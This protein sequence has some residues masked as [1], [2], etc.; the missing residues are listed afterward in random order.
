MAALLATDA[1]RPRGERPTSR[2]ARAVGHVAATLGLAAVFVASTVGGA[3]LHLDLGPAR[4]LVAGVV[5]ATVFSTAFTGRL[6][7]GAID[8]LGL[9]GVRIRSFD[10]FDPDGHRVVHADGIEA[11]FDALSNVRRIASGDLDIV[12]A[13]AHIVD[14]DA[15]ISSRDGVFGIAETFTP[16]PLPVPPPPP[17]PPTVPPAPLRFTIES[18]V[19]DHAAGHGEL[20]PGVHLDGDVRKVDASLHVLPDTVM[21]DVDTVEVEERAITPF[22]VSGVANYHLRV[23]SKERPDSL[24]MWTG[25]GGKIGEAALTATATI[26]DDVLKAHVDV[27]RATPA[28]LAGFAPGLELRDAVT[29]SGDLDGTIPTFSISA[30][31]GLLGA[32]GSTGKIDVDG[33]LDAVDGARV[34]ADVHAVDV[35]LG[36]VAPVTA[37]P[38][39]ADVRVRVDLTTMRVTA[40][41]TTQ[42]F[43]IEGQ[44]VPAVQAFAI[45][46]DGEV[47]GSATIDEDGAPTTAA[48]HVRPSGDVRFAATADVPSLQAFPRIPGAPVSGSAHVKV[49]GSLAGGALDARVSGTASGLGVGNDVRVSRAVI[50]GR[51]HG[52]LAA[53]VLDAG[54][55]GGGLQAGTYDFDTY[56][57]RATGPLLA[58][59][60]S[61][62]LDGKANGQVTARAEVDA[63]TASAHAITLS[64]KK[65]DDE[66]E[67]KVTRVGVVRGGVAIEGVS[68]EGEKVG[69]VAANLRIDRGELVGRV[70]GDEVDVQ[71]LARLLSLPISAKGI[72]NVDVDLALTPRG[73]KGH[74]SI[75]I[76][77]G[78]FAGI[79]GVST[80]F[81][82][83]FDDRKVEA[84]ALV[85]LVSRARPEDK[86]HSCDGAIARVRIEQGEGELDGPLL[87]PRT[88]AH[89][90]GSARISAEQWDLRCLAKLGPTALVLSDVKGRLGVRFTVA[91]GKGDR[92]PSVKDLLAR[93]TEL[94]LA[95]PIPSGSDSPSWESRH[96]DVQLNGDFDGRTG[97]TTARA[98]VLDEKV[99]A[100]VDVRASPDVARLIDDPAGRFAS[101]RKMPL[102]V[103][104]RMPRRPMSS[105]TS[106]PSFVVAALPAAVGDLSA[107][108]R[109]DGTLEKPY[110]A[111][112]AHARGL[113]AA[114]NGVADA[115]PWS[116]PIEAELSGSYDGD[117]ATL[118]VRT[119]HGDKTLLKAEARVEDLPMAALL[120]GSIPNWKGSVHAQ[121]KEAPVGDIPFFVD[122]E[123]SGTL[124]GAL[125]VEGLHQK[126]T[127]HAELD[128]PGLR[129]GED[130][131]FT[132][133]K[134]VLDVTREGAASVEPGGVD[135]A[136]ARASVDLAG[137]G[138]GE[139][140]VT[141]NAGVIWEGGVVPL[142]DPDAPGGVEVDASRFRLLALQPAV[143]GVLSK[144]DGLLDGKV[145]L[146]WKK[147]SD[148]QAGTLTADLHVTKGV[149]H[150]PQLGQEF[151]NA[152]VDVSG[153]GDGTIRISDL[154]ADGAQAGRVT[155][156]GEV[157]LDG[158]R[159]KQAK[160]SLAVDEG[161][162]LPVNLEGVPL[163][164]FRAKVDV[165]ATKDEKANKLDVQLNIPS[166]H[167]E[168][169]PSPG[170]G[171]QEMDDNPEIKVSHALHAEA[172][173]K[174]R[175][176]T[177][178]DLTVRIDE[179]L[180]E[181][182][183]LRITLKSSG[184]DPP[185]VVVEGGESSVT[186]DVHLVRGKLSVFGKD[187]T[188]EETAPN[189]VHMAG[190]PS[191]PYLNV[192]ARWDAPDGTQV[193]I[194]YI[195]PLQPMTADR[196]KLRSIPSY[197]PDQIMSALLLGGD[198]SASAAPTTTQ[199]QAGGVATNAAGSVAAQQFNSL[200]SGIG[201]LRGLSTRIATN[202]D[203]SLATSLVYDISDKFSAT[204]TFDNGT[205]QTQGAPGATTSSQASS[206]PMNG[207]G[208]TAAQQGTRTQLSVDWHFWRN[209]LLRG[210]VILGEDQP[211]S[212]LDF[213][214]QYRY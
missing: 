123:I 16:K 110:L 191:N 70:R 176:G 172:E 61:A 104:F 165:V 150:V 95:G 199:A 200:L 136:T 36:A 94:E 74:A 193:F 28:E 189:L 141:A 33:V 152:K 83:T 166:L 98:A 114:E 11:S 109:F 34:S 209:W 164:N 48:F 203:G 32:H 162:D 124:S 42:P 169:P 106:L 19:I 178:L 91:R 168:L 37:T 56:E 57:V 122:R 73:R 103:D 111:Y 40:D 138:G 121:I 120:D 23:G 211:T 131:T 58:P 66:L 47:D 82:A 170:R 69:K 62:N 157:K 134:I 12:I 160:V 197:S 9:G 125:D 117:R 46:Q 8:H 67:G 147:F 96:V 179:A 185:H 148:P 145:R 144:L 208:G 39:S 187:F 60:V 105:L 25:I 186:G 167:L 18:I 119:R 55:R 78:A 76:E 181:G 85:R 142:P 17:P 77:D 201:P 63:K 51:V 41:A 24:D 14:A 196:I 112:R 151:T 194:D 15:V 45:V 132:R 4:R 75:E 84:D 93:T 87:D 213:L 92:F 31:V 130:L 68:L 204:A 65:G 30:K 173:I 163:G 80:L 13:S 133:N 88:W 97:E 116:L 156:K 212:G 202:Q 50:D 153:G 143:A 135:R 71:R 59:H 192:T 115:S 72:A 158:L 90:Y 29:L 210:S 102:T 171:V 89:A 154:S 195:G 44:V 26:E 35:D 22:P 149:F 198:F 146:G 174:E 206:L 86:D 108:F 214:W 184:K 81:T 180:I 53:L 207:F 161:H 79:S 139:L 5:N 64:V 175:A 188:I 7:V 38:A 190:D 2:F 126:P 6:A 205:G 99:I 1:A 21:V 100:E 101:L 43:T 129:I 140:K 54:V 49:D 107:S 52:P 177:K 127:V 10:A 3:L 159:L 182:K 128:M 183:G 27:P 118:D 20:V 113:S 137:R 155:G